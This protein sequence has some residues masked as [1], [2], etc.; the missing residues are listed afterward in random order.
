MF[1]QLLLLSNTLPLS[2]ADD[3][4]PLPTP[5]PTPVPHDDVLGMPCTL[6]LSPEPLS[7]GFCC[8]TPH[9]PLAGESYGTV[10]KGPKITEYGQRCL[11]SETCQ[12]VLGA[13]GTEHSSCLREGRCCSEK[14]EYG[15]S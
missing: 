15:L 6:S 7:P 9:D 3:P 8:Y 4:T 14:D 5:L 11:F 13:K 10:Q 12:D 1:I 2:K